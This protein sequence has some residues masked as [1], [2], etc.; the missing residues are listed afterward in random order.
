ME[1]S[2]SMFL[3]KCPKHIK[4]RQKF[5][6]AQEPPFICPDCIEDHE[7]QKVHSPE[8]LNRNAC[9]KA[10]I[11]EMENI[12]YSK[13]I[14]QITKFLPSLHSLISQIDEEIKTMTLEAIQA[15]SNIKDNIMQ[16]LLSR[17]NEEN[18]KDEINQSVPQ[19]HLKYEEMK[20]II[21][22]FSAEQIQ[23]ISELKTKDFRSVI[24]STLD[25]TIVQHVSQA[26][27]IQ[28]WVGT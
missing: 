6:C 7:G 14:E 3:G 28:E 20:E 15:K 8:T 11:T 25:S 13:L 10:M 16:N 18:C 5:F 12:N 4:K 23:L 17:L 27:L 21:N 26:G 19:L 1:S 24:T 2:K 9:S 22:K